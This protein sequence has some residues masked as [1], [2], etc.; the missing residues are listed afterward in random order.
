MYRQ[1]RPIVLLNGRLRREEISTQMRTSTGDCMQPRKGAKGQGKARSQNDPLHWTAAPCPS[2][3]YRI[4]NNLHSGGD[5]CQRTRHGTATSLQAFQ[6]SS[7]ARREEDKR[8]IYEIFHAC[9]L[10]YGTRRERERE[11][12]APRKSCIIM[13]DA[14]CTKR[15]KGKIIDRE[16]SFFSVEEKGREGRRREEAGKTPRTCVH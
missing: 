4:E 1:T 16:K 3:V 14:R 11:R 6:K 13:P 15:G 10:L 5:R 9:T 7:G 12:I 8:K 2:T